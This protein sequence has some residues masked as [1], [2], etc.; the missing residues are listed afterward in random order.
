MTTAMIM[1]ALLTE[2]YA[3]VISYSEYT[4]LNLPPGAVSPLT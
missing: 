2:C 3:I 1:D 4:K